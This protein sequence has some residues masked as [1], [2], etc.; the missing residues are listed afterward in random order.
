M[1]KRSK[2]KDSSPDSGQIKLSVPWNDR[3]INSNVFIPERRHIGTPVD[4]EQWLEEQDSRNTFGRTSDDAALTFLQERTRV[5]ETY[6]KEQER[7]KRIGMILSVVLILGAAALILFAPA[8]R[9]TLSYWI[10]AALVIFAAGAMGYQRVWG[11]SKNLSFG[12]DQDRRD[13]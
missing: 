5:H 10:G 11:K 8:G 13:L 7:T 2:D 6:I 1:A 9:E 3:M 4:R 12:A